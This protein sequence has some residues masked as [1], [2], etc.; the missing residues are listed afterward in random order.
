MT[1]IP[2]ELRTSD[3]FDGTRMIIHERRTCSMEA[4]MATIMLEK[5]GM[6]A[7]A[8]DGEDSA[9]RSKLHLSTPEELVTRACNTAAAAVAEFERRGWLVDVPSYDE[10]KKMADADRGRN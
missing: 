9:G 5:W 2:I 3:R 4:R 8:P 1:R 6:V 7:A 10:L